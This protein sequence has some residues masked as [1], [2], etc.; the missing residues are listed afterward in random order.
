MDDRVV[1]LAIDRAASKEILSGSLE[2]GE[3]AT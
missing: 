2:A 3:E 1:G